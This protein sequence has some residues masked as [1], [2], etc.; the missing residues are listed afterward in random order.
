MDR[1]L[2]G[3]CEVKFF[4]FE[5]KEGKEVFWHS[6]AHVLGEAIEIDF[7][8]HLTHG[9]PTESGFFYDSYTGTDKFA[10]SHY[11]KIEDRAKKICNEK[12]KFERIILTKEEALKMFNANPFKVSMI[13]SK[14]PDG[15]SVSA[16]RCGDLI[17]LCT[18]PHVP[19]TDAIKAFKVLKNS[20][21]NWL[22]KVDLDS[23]QRIYGISFPSKKELDEWVHI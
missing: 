6:S 3:N 9:P 12:Q 21:S 2:E 8:V 23:L 16:Y 14:I 15:C 10:E 4:S 5:D 1:P 19:A 18:G 13:D 20:S 11:K 17:D 7:G 22:G